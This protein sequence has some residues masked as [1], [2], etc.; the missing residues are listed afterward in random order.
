M[1]LIRGKAADQG[2]LQ[3]LRWSGL[4]ERSE[5]KDRPFCGYFCACVPP[6]QDDDKAKKKLTWPRAKREIQDLLGIIKSIK[7]IAK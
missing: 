5:E 3:Q 4:I 1:K 7:S 2:A 6:F